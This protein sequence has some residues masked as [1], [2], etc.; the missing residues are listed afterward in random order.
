V[1]HSSG[2]KCSKIQGNHHPDKRVSI[3]FKEKGPG[4]KTRP[5]PCA[6]FGYATVVNVAMAP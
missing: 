3:A 6:E 4:K 2:K 5:F 1:F